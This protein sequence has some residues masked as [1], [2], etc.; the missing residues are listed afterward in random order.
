M[1]DIDFGFAE[2][3]RLVSSLKDTT[4]RV[5]K[6]VPAV[7]QEAG[8]RVQQRAKFFAP[9]DTGR[10][11]ENIRIDSGGVFDVTVTS[12]MGYSGFQEWGTSRMNPQPYMGP[13]AE[14]VTPEFQDDIGTVGKR[15]M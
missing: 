3:S 10:L 14:T 6:D 8:T 13:A 4:T 12:H 7:V 1:A 11:R 2:V 9:V 5:N 15:I